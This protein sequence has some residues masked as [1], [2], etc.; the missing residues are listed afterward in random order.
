MTDF[1]RWGDSLGLP[2]FY[3]LLAE[4]LAEKLISGKLDAGG[5]SE[6]DWTPENAR[7]LRVFIL[8]LGLQSERGHLRTD[9]NSLED[10]FAEWYGQFGEMKG[11]DKTLPARLSAQNKTLIDAA[12][13]GG[14]VGRLETEHST[15]DSFSVPRPPLVLSADGR[16][17]YF[18]RRRR[19]EDVLIDALE[20]RCSAGFSSVFP[21]PARFPELAGEGSPEAVLMKQLASGR[22][23]LILSGGPGTGKTSTIGRLVSLIEEGRRDADMMEAGI[24]AAAPTG[25]AAA[26]MSEGLP[27][28]TGRTLHSLLGVVPHRPPRHNRDNPLDAELLIVDEASMVD[29]PMMNRILDALPPSAAL[30]LVGDPDQLP[31]V[32]AGALLADLLEGAAAGSTAAGSSQGGAGGSGQGGAA[33]RAETGGTRE[34]GGQDAAGSNSGG[35]LGGAVVR[36]SKVYRS[37]TEILDAAAAL[38]EGNLELFLQACTKDSIQFRP[39][40][41][42]D[43][44]ARTLADIYKPCVRNN[45]SFEEYNAH[46][47]LTPLRKGLMGVPALNR[48]VSI[49]LGAAEQPFPGMPLVVTRNDARRE[50]W[51]GDRGV[52]R[53]TEQGL[54]ACFPP[55]EPG[56]E[57]RTFPLAALEGWEPAWVQTIHRSQGSEFQEVSVIL[58]PEAGRLLTREIL[59][60]AFTRARKKVVLYSDEETVS[61]ALSQRVVRLSRVSDW[62]SGKGRV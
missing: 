41:R 46:T 33:G 29:V 19:E 18:L 3:V 31:S 25:R 45:V 40:P 62:A 51:N 58:P 50:L 23:L 59:Y 52:I 20:R 13:A 37:N 47:V 4:S 34:A 36:L 44:M 6:A 8:H 24:T 7:L 56:G 57:I 43:V 42:P 5:S 30:L 15:A 60:T 35:P 2:A 11:Y 32:E 26:R 39:V 48:E 28:L 61:K 27:G 17:L 16:Y 54:R 49:L 21:L 10:D 14:L 9:L 55:A 1:V 38:R 53:A 12:L 22:R